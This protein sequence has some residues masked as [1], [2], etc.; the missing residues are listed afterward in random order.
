MALVFAESVALT[1]SGG[2]IG[3]LLGV[4]MTWVLEHADL[5]RGKIDAVFSLPFLAGTL[6]LSVVLGIAGGAFPALKAARMRPAQAL[7]H[8]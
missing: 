4:A 7:R 3:V 5:L 6:A 1:V 2:A 8:E